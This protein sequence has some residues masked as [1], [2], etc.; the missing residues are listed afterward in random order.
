MLCV[1][2]IYFMCSFQQY[3]VRYINALPEFYNG[4]IYLPG[5]LHHSLLV[6]TRD[7]ISLIYPESKKQAFILVNSQ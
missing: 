4:A 3:H 6:L 7:L 1:F 2:S 5:N